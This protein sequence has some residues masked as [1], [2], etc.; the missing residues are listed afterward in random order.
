MTPTLATHLTIHEPELPRLEISDEHAGNGRTL[1]GLPPRP[2]VFGERWR[3]AI[4]SP[5]RREAL[6]RRLLC[7]A[8]VAAGAAAMV[9]V[10]TLLGNNRLR[11]VT[12]AGTPVI[13]L[14]FKVAGL[15]DRDQLRLLRSTLDEAPVLVQVT[16]LYALALAI[17][18]PLIVAGHLWGGQIAALWV[19]SF[20]T[21]MGFRLFARW[22]AGRAC[23][24]ERCLVI[25][26]PG[27]AAR[28][29]EKLASTR[30]RVW[31]RLHCR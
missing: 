31:S 12:L 1:I 16:G 21:I 11:L 8:D 4:S 28:I 20:L 26:D 6:R 5:R 24:P 25:G 3:G 9:F 2:F 7:V 27:L 14:L 30:A 10:L 15:Y 23:V 29:S 22:V 13:I 17:L 19:T 18:Q